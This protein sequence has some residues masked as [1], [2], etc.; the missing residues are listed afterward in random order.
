MV[1][2][3]IKISKRQKYVCGTNPNKCPF[4]SRFFAE[5]VLCGN[6]QIILRHR[7]RTLP[8]RNTGFL[9][10][11]KLWP[12]TRNSLI[13]TSP[14]HKLSRTWIIP[15][16]LNQTEKCESVP[17][18]AATVLLLSH[19]T[20]STHSITNRERWHPHLALIYK[21]VIPQQKPS[22]VQEQDQQDPNRSQSDPIVK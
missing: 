14:L 3:L 10:P 22:L 12:G 13:N 8:H 16:L 5:Q 9:P 18:H 6:L 15:Y 11:P 17:S 20:S 4:L 21:Q 1:Q 2:T 7:T 19:T